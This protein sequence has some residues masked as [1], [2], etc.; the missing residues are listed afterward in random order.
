MP[1]PTRD[2]LLAEMAA[3][4]RQLAQLQQ[5]L[6]AQQAGSGAIAQANSTAAGAGGV[7]VR[8]DVHGNIYLGPPTTDP[9]AALA[10]YCRVFVAACRQLPLRSID[11]GASDPT[12]NRKQ[13]DLDQVYVALDTTT[14]VP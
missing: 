10:I 3:M 4:Q 7:A 9:V 6:S 11:I 2:E 14:R 13:L 5:Q 12:G 1:E 8:G